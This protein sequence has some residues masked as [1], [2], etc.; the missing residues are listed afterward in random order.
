[1]YPLLITGGLGLVAG[2][3]PMLPPH[4]LPCRWDGCC[5]ALPLPACSV[6][7]PQLF[8]MRWSSRIQAGAS[9]SGS[10]G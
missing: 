8:Q 5:P 10:S 6:V 7:Q 3:Q 4:P 2:R 9:P 1:M